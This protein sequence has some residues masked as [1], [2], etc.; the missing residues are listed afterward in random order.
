MIAVTNSGTSLVKGLCRREILFAADHLALLR[1]ELL[2]MLSWQV[3]RSGGSFSVGKNYKYLPRYLQAGIQERLMETYRTDS[4]ESA[5][6]SLDGSLALFRE[7]AAKVAVALAYAYPAYD[8]YITP[9]VLSMRKIQNG[10][11]FV[12][13]NRI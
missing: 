6:D 3:G 10:D 9:R 7:S 1:E 11:G 5:W 13:G 12:R 8:G 2:R 4:Y